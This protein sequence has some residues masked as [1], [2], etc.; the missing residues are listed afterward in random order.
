MRRVVV[1]GLGIISPA[2][3]DIKSFW[4]SLI[5]GKCCIDFITKFD[6]TDFNVKVAAE[7]KNFDKSVLDR[8]E[9]SRSDLYTQYAL[10]AAIQAYGD[11]GIEGKIDKSR[12]GVF[13][14]SGI[15]G[16]STFATEYDK[17]R[18]SGP[19]R[20]SPFF[21]PMMIAN[22]AS[23]Y[24]SMRFGAKG[25]SLP[26]VSACA[27]GTQSIGEA[28]RAIK[29]GY[30]DAI[31]TGG[32]EA[33]IIPVA[34]AGFASC[35]ALSTKTIPHLCSLPFDKRRDGFVMGEGAGVLMLEEL[36]HAV[37]RNAKIY[38]EVTGYGNTCDAYHITAPDPSGLSAAAA[39]RAAAG[40]DFAPEKL[41]I[42]AHGTGTQLNDKYETLA[43]KLAL[44][45]E[46]A[47]KV[48][49]SS[50]K[51]MVGH[52][53]GAAGAAEA[54]ASVLALVHNTVPPTISL[55]EP[56]PECD[57][58]YTPKTAL[59]TELDT[60]LSTSLGFGGHNACIAFRK[61]DI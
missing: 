9:I 38:A 3:N 58:D 57:L 50:I 2:G 1:T 8:K 52:M 27:T 39:I 40:N 14:S 28:Y 31:I 49:I 55:D 56:D 53:L 20:V 26:V 61:I 5:S 54:I 37:K 46:A 10:A 17:F 18:D 47:Y 6:T 29:H 22:M 16:I 48:H 51:S 41:Y 13:I 45:P 11:S 59:K 23:G 44:T 7:V 36:S 33:S 25:P 43:I 30:A 42:N 60:A 32:S 15:G 12:L 19:R 34:I 21:V 35:M 4:N 24:V